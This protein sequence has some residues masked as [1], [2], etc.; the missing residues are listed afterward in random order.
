MIRNM[1]TQSIYSK[2]G[3][4]FRPTSSSISIR[5]TEDPDPQPNP[6]SLGKEKLSARCLVISLHAAVMTVDSAA[7]SPHILAE[8]SGIGGK[9]RCSHY[10]GPGRSLGV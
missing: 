4:S 7:C 10:A 8:D 5:Y 3:L 9:E 2:L 1:G 6:V